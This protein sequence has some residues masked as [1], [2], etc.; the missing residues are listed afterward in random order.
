[1]KGRFGISRRVLKWLAAGL[2]GVAIGAALGYLLFAPKVLRVAV[3]P[4]GGADLRVV[5]GYLQTLQRERAPIRFKL[6]LTDG[7]SSSAAAVES[8]RADLAVIRPDVRVPPSTGTVAILRRD[9]VY[10][11]ARPNSG[12]AAPADLKGK[13][14]GLIGPR[15]GNQKI[16]NQLLAYYDVPKAEVT[17][18][19]L[20]MQELVPAIHSGEVDAVFVVAPVGDRFARDVARAFRGDG[21][22]EVGLVAIAEAD[23]LASLD[24]ALDTTEIPRGAFG[25]T[26]AWPPEARTTLAV[27]H[28]LVARQSLA[29][30]TVSDLT[31]LLVS[32]RLQV[33]TEVAAANQVELPG[34]DDRAAKL[35]VHPGTIAY[36]EG[37]TK[38]FFERYGDWIYMGIFGASLAGSVLAALF[39]GLMRARSEG[40]STPLERMVALRAGL[41][42]DPTP[43]RRREAADA[44]EAILR[45]GLGNGRGRPDPTELTALLLLAEELRRRLAA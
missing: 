2:V 15:P 21:A 12:I 39:S 28:R 32:L 25:G 44:V 41:E 14:I 37:E 9:A 10:F 42:P 6:V 13:R 40:P 33:A 29:E 18:R 17:L 45:E 30:E 16:F 1:M 35:P 23:A 24:P 26:P 27:S 43:E 19:P 31:R 36:G 20:A 34:T 8:G 11:I 3:G 7:P 4:V 5:V 22:G 38:T